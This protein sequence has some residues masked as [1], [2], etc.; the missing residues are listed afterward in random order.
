MNQPNLFDAKTETAFEVYH[1]ENPAVYVLFKRFSFEAIEK[2]RKHFSAEA[3]INRIRWETLI[4]G[5]DDFKI[6]NNYKA[7]YSRLF[8]KD[9]PQYSGFFE[10]RKSKADN[11]EI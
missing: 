3:V 9:F 4:S 8:M 10:L 1:R 11:L 2:G 5:N 6:N 7:F